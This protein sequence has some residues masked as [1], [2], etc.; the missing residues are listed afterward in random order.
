MCSDLERQSRRGVR[1]VDKH[2][3]KRAIVRQRFRPGLLHKKQRR[4]PSVSFFS[5]SI[6]VRGL[7]WQTVSPRDASKEKKRWRLLLYLLPQNEFVAINVGRDVAVQ[8]ECGA[9]GPVLHPLALHT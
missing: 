6:A 2:P 8:R 4:G 3:S 7:W 1:V 5:I 9:H